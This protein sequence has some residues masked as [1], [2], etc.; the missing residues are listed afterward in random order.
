[1]GLFK[2]KTEN[3]LRLAKEAAE[4][5]TELKD[6]FVSL[7]AHDLRSPFITIL[8]F[9]KLILRD[10]DHP[11]HEK[12]RET[13]ERV[14]AQGEELDELIRE[15]LDISRFK[16]G[17]LRPDSHFFDGHKVAID[18]IARLQYQAKKKGI[19]LTCDVPNGTRLYADVN[20]YN[21]VIQNL[22]TNAIKFC[23][24]GGS[25]TMFVP[26]GES[27]TI[28]VKDTGIGIKE[29]RHTEIFK[30]EERTSTPGTSGERGTGLG[31]PLI[32]DIMN[33]HGGT[34]EFDSKPGKGSTFYARLPLVHPVV[35][36][37][38]DDPAI[39]LMLR[40]LLEKINSQIIEAE[41][42]KEALDMLA[43]TRPDLV[44]ADISMPIMDGYELLEH[45]RKN[46]SLKDIPIIIITADDQEATR[47]RV[48]S[49]G[50]NDFVNKPIASADFVP[51][52]RRYIG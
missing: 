51:R 39:R 9:L 23:N 32:R 30:Y 19:K 4:K 8:G 7:V 29:E 37:V 35:L 45:I 5:A 36:I 48:F 41:N 43:G 42:S 28:A 20:L 12:H 6:K 46:L 13:I 18:T 31:L 47:E 49:L 22:L 25:I 26:D 16:T 44:V 11:L 21:Q 3:N 33:S 38:E 17:K 10:K 52:V 24:K 27:A 2:H 1:M 15:L 40:K 50:A 14:V 34:L